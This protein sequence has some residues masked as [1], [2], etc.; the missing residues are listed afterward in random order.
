MPSRDTPV[1]RFRAMGDGVDT[2]LATV[3]PEELISCSSTVRGSLPV[4]Y[5]SRAPEVVGGVGMVARGDSSSDLHILVQSGPLG[6]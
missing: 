5:Y 4:C 1:T 3:A 6:K 2:T